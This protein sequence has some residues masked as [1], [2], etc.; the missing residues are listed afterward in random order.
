[1]NHTKIAFLICFVLLTLCSCEKNEIDTPPEFTTS[2]NTS[3]SSENFAK[4]TLNDGNEISFYS[5]DDKQLSGVFLLEESDC[6]E[7]SALDNLSKVSENK[8]S[9]QEIFWAL[10]EPGTHVPHFLKETSNNTKSKNGTSLA[11]GWGRNTEKI[12]PIIIGTLPIACNNSYFTNSIADGFIGTPEFVRLDKTP[13]NYSAFKNDCANLAPSACNNGPRYKFSKTYSGIKEWKGKICSRAVQNSSNNHYNGYT[14]CY[15]QPCN[16]GSGYI[17]PELYFEYKWNGQWK[18]IKN[19][20]QGG[21]KGFEV[22]ANKTKVYTYSLST[23]QT[24]SFRLRVKNAMKK[25]QFDFMIDKKSSGENGGSLDQWPDVLPQTPNYINLTNGTFG[26]DNYR[27]TIDFN[28][29]DQYSGQPEISLPVAFLP[30]LPEYEGEVVFPTNFCGFRVVDAA[31]F[32]FFDDNNKAINNNTF[33]YVEKNTTI[34]KKFGVNEIEFSGP[35]GACQGGSSTNFWKFLSPMTNSQTPPVLSYSNISKLVIE[36]NPG[37]SQIQF[38]NH[39]NYFPNPL[40]ALDLFGNINV[41]DVAKFF[42]EIYIGSDQWLAEVED[43]CQSVTNPIAC[44][45]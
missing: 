30:I 26:N 43:V 5:I 44:P 2:Q 29:L 45:F 16:A 36:L 33:N 7:C 32:I 23:S 18:S 37:V 31:R 9:G 22:P 27:I 35:I 10:S 34:F 4:I 24:T 21:P 40:N 42:N 28:N 8:L 15:P 6:G 19:I 13:A 3:G 17:G 25:D 1:M 14:F 38:V 39:N 11:Q 12:S 41:F 20:F